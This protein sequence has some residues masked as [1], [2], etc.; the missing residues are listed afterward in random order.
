MGRGSANSNI[1]Y[2][3]VSPR[4]TPSRLWNHLVGKLDPESIHMGPYTSYMEDANGFSGNG[5]WMVRRP[6]LPKELKVKAARRAPGS[7]SL[8]KTQ[9]DIIEHLLA[10]DSLQYSSSQ[11]VFEP[12]NDFTCRVIVNPGEEDESMASKELSQFAVVET[13]AG[14]PGHWRF[15]HDRDN[16]DASPYSQLIYL[17]KSGELLG[18]IL[19]VTL[20][21]LLGSSKA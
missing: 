13:L 16:P 17:D 19:G 3:S 8:L 20:P 1:L 7:N 5:W 9:K 10:Q 12:M 11:P 2:G 4:A 14:E 21:I 15:Y 6:E 18:G